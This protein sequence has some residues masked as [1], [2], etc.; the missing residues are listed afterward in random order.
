MFSLPRLTEIGGSF[1]PCL[2]FAPMTC[3][4]TWI[5]E[6]TSRS[7]RGFVEL[8]PTARALVVELGIGRGEALELVAGA[9][10]LVALRRLGLIGLAQAEVVEVGMEQVEHRLDALAGVRELVDDAFLAI[11]LD[12]VA[13]HAGKLH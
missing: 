10:L 12:Q 9:S 8:E 13:D 4:L 1:R 5:R 7:L 3:L 6:S 11:G 2:R